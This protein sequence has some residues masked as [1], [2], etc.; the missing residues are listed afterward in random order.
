MM[1]ESGKLKRSGGTGCFSQA[2]GAF[3]EMLASGGSPTREADAQEAIE[4]VVTAS[5][6]QARV[7]G[8]LIGLH[9]TESPFQA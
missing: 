5:L 6:V 9:L 3:K 7:G 8:T 4:Q 1:E 2:G